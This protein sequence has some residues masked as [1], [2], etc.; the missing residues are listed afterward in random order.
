MAERII[1]SAVGTADPFEGIIRSLEAMADPVEGIIPPAEGTADPFEGITHSAEGMA[2]P[3]EGIA[4][5]SG[6]GKG[7]GGDQSRGNGARAPQGCSVLGVRGREQDPSALSVPVNDG[8]YRR[9]A[10]I[11]EPRRHGGHR[12]DGRGNPSALSVPVNDGM[13]RRAVADSPTFVQVPPSFDTR[14]E[15]HSGLAGTGRWEKESECQVLGATRV[16]GTASERLRDVRGGIR[17]VRVLL[18]V[19]VLGFSA[20][21]CWTFDV[22]CSLPVPPH[23]SPL[24]PHSCSSISRRTMS[25]HACTVLVLGCSS[26]RNLRSMASAREMCSFAPGRSPRSRITLPRL[27]RRMA[28]L[29]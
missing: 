29:G 24:S 19:I 4:P 26:P 28:T 3:A 10:G 23:S 9:A 6:G 12:E 15:A 21:R 13:Y 20:V 8:M 5:T 7:V 1:L 16:A 14:P 17:L 27:L 18:I 2:D 11:V 25:S 22:R